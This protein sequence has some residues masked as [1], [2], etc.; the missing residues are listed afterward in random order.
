[1]KA[2]KFDTQKPATELLSRVALEGVARVL[3][4]G[5]Q[6]YAAHNWR[7][8]MEW[9]R[10]AG[11]AM[12]HLLAFIDGEDIDPESGLPHVDHLMCCAMFLS[13]YQKK[14][15]GTDNRHTSPTVKPYVFVT[16]TREPK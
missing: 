14:N 4:F 10:V 11:A 12:R 1:M 9:G 13:E 2:I 16:H 7:L 5:A 8:G 3:G 15:L 6:K